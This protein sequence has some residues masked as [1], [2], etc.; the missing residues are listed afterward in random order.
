MIETVLFVG[1][2]EFRF[3]RGANLCKLSTKFTPVYTGL[4][5]VNFLVIF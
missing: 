4:L 2:C 3:H 1:K 5:S